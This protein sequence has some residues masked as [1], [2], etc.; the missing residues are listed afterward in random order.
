MRAAEQLA[1]VRARL[2]WEIVD[3]AVRD[4][5]AL[6]RR[7]RSA[8]AT[9][10]ARAAARRARTDAERTVKNALARADGLI[11]DAIELLDKLVAIEPTMERVSLIGSAYKR[12]ALVDGAAGRRARVR[13]DLQQMRASYLAAQREGER[14]G[15]DDLYYPATNRLTAEVALNAGTPRWRSLDRATVALVRKSLQ[16][17]RVADP[18]FWSVVGETELDQYEAIAA[19]RLAR[20]RAE[21]TRAYDDLHTR[22]TA[23]RMWGSVYDTAC[24]VL[25]NYASRAKG[26]ER[27]AALDLLARLRLFA[28]PE[29]HADAE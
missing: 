17:R 5:D 1:N 15:G 12:K 22:V 18:D 28:H 14:S 3:R 26:R 13:R 11:D 24:L 16:A 9:P 4:R 25:P 8:D 23:T 10:Q 2:A 27:T 6:R 29:E 7:E 21:L 19:G 20:A